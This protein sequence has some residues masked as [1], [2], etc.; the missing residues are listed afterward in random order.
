VVSNEF[1]HKK[2]NGP[3]C[4][5]YLLVGGVA[6]EKGIKRDMHAIAYDD[7]IQ[8]DKFFNTGSTLL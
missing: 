7:L 6:W 4:G 5:S 3:M 1:E 8:K 2:V